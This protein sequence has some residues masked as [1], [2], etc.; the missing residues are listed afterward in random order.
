MSVDI[1]VGDNLEILKKMPDDSVQCVIT[2]P[3]YWGLR[4]YGI[5]EAI[6]LESS[7]DQ[8]IE[9]LVNVFSEVFRVLHPEGT[10]WLNYG[11]MYAGSGRGVIVDENSM[12]ANN[13]GTLN[14]GEL[15][16]RKFQKLPQGLKPKDLILAGAMLAMR[17]QEKGWYLRSEIIWA[18]LN[19]MPE[20]V[21]DR[22]TCAHEKIFLFSKRPKYF[23]DHYSVKTP[24]REGIGKPRGQ[25]RKR[26]PT[27]MV[28]GIRAKKQDGHGPRHAGFND[29]WNG[30]EQEKTANLRNVWRVS[31][32]PFKGAHF[33]VFPMGIVETCIKAGTSLK[34]VC[35]CCGKQW[36]RKLKTITTRQEKPSTYKENTVKV[37]DDWRPAESIGWEP[38]T[39]KCPPEFNHD[40][41][42]PVI[43]DPFAGAGTTGLVADNMGRDAILIEINPEYAEMARD[44]IHSN[45]PL[46]IGEM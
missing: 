25:G 11:D 14:L 30:Q 29:R 4:D 33:A 2:S 20:S 31:N 18:K 45:N 9:R 19:P 17:L 8:H 39:D 43:L 42:P 7:L 37:A 24:S 1:R 23:Y 6:G 13:K 16:L 41:R 22:P 34:G 38:P 21:T 27:D 35:K 46:F 12:Q 15:N 5:K 28:N 10:F 3:P 26:E 44:R 32:N 40:V 36:R